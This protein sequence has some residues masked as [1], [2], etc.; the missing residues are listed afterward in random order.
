ML[1]R[2]FRRVKGHISSVLNRPSAMFW[3]APFL[4]AVVAV[5]YVNRYEAPGLI[6]ATHSLIVRVIKEGTPLALIAMGT[7]LVL[8]T[9]GVDISTAGVA[10]AGGIIFA[11][12]SQLGSP[13]ILCF[14]AALLFGV[15]SGLG[16]GW[17]VYRNLPPLILSWA[18]GAL[19]FVVSLVFADSGLVKGTTSGVWLDFVPP[20]DYWDFGGGGFTKSILALSLTVFLIGLTNLPRRA[21]AVGANRDSAI[22]AGIKT[23]GVYLA[24]YSLSGA[25]SALAGSLWALLNTG[26][27]TV[28]H[29]GKELVAI[30]IA[31][32]GGTVMTGGY[33]FLPSV[34]AAAF[35]WICL[36]TI[37]LGSDL[38][39]FQ[40][41][42]QQVA[43]GLF[44]IL[45][46]LLLLPLGRRLSGPTQ[47]INAE[48]KVTEVKQ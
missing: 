26:A 9:G 13:Q 21:R 33:L 18:L 25:L 29:A 47:T 28:E 5:V 38:S 14:V 22:Y 1:S 19:W 20:A 31:I 32:L 11:A 40:E 41:F 46:I 15:L 6:P 37:V 27:P 39:I 34:I 48:Q 10:T 30:A 3:I 4:L 35:F 36:Q 16:L 12:T 17:G 42:Q 7:A 44:A 23:R 43:N 8:S 24:T 2:L 45:F